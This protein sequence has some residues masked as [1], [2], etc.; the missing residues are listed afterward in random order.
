MVYINVLI[1]DHQTELNWMKCVILDGAVAIK[2]IVS[3]IV[4]FG[5]VCIMDDVTGLIMLG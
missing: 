3:R 2:I 1:Y 5:I 4:R